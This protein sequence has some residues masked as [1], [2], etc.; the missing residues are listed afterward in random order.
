MSASSASDWLPVLRYTGQ[1]SETSPSL[2]AAGHRIA[3]ALQLI[4]VGRGV[5]PGL[6]SGARG[7]NRRRDYAPERQSGIP[8]GEFLRVG[9]LRNSTPCLP[10]RA[11]TNLWPRSRSAL[12]VSL[13]VAVAD[14]SV[15]Q[16]IMASCESSFVAYADRLGFNFTPLTAL[17]S[18]SRIVLRGET[19]GRTGR[20][21]PF[22]T[23][24]RTRRVGRRGSLWAGRV[25]GYVR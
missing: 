1:C 23:R 17:Y 6:L 15:S 18:A 19:R 8:V 4:A 5:C 7:L 11:S 14:H 25:A 24:A 10:R 12:S 13:P 3:K 21:Y 16:Q 2:V 9:W 22:G 20:A